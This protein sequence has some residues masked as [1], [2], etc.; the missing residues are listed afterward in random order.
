MLDMITMWKL[1]YLRIHS[2]MNM[3]I[4]QRW[5]LWNDWYSSSSREHHA[6]F[7]W[8]MQRFVMMV[9]FM[10]TLIFIKYVFFASSLRFHSCN[11]MG[12]CFMFL[13]ISIIWRKQYMYIATTSSDREISNANTK[14]INYRLLA[15][16][17]NIVCLLT[18]CW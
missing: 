5:I 12:N 14:W 8:T 4:I 11:V 2:M 9:P 13:S 6:R 15:T 7:I 1:K 10:I 3:D 16:Q 17:K 18:W